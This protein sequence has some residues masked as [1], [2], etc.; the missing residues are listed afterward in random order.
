ML[1]YLDIQSCFSSILRKENKFCDFLFSSTVIKSFQKGS[2]LEEKK[3]LQEEQILSFGR[4]IIE[5]GSKNESDSCF[6]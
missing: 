5:K 6:P 4:P 2:A 1:G 3:L